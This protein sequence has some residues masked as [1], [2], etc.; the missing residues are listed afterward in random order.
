MFSK[1]FLVRL[2]HIEKIRKGEVGVVDAIVKMD[3]SNWNKLVEAGYR[4]VIVKSELYY[5]YPQKWIGSIPL[6]LTLFLQDA[7][8]GNF[9]NSLRYPC[10]CTLKRDV[11][12]KE[13]TESE[14]KAIEDIKESDVIANE[15][16]D[17]ILPE[18]SQKQMEKVVIAFASSAPKIGKSETV[19]RLQAELISD[20]TVMP[21]TIAE[22]IRQMLVGVAD[23][24]D[25]DSSRFFENYHLK[26]QIIKFGNEPL[27]FKT[28]D[29][30]CEFSILLQKFY[31]TDIWGQMA[32][33]NIENYLANVVLIDDLRRPDEYEVIKKHFGARLITVYLDKVDVENKQ[34]NANLSDAAK[35]FESKLNKEEMDIQFTFNE[36]WSNLPD[37]IKEIKDKLKSLS[38]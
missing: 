14:K 36:D 29:L 37:L 17:L 11:Y 1:K 2:P 8:K 31:G 16:D 9:F 21:H 27:E 33:K 18:P 10:Y 7:L 24:L 28:R 25:V 30:L 32:I 3:K 34:V 22:Y 19:K 6:Y 15:E 13:L 23:D 5:K 35:A 12:G 26:D 38:N 20:Y 4:P